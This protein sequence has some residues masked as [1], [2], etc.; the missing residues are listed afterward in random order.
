MQQDRRFLQIKPFCN[1]VCFFQDESILQ[2]NNYVTT[3]S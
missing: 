1:L 2:T 3:A